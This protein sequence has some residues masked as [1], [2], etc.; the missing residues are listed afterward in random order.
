MS[1]LEWIARLEAL[2]S[3]GHGCASEQGSERQQL[4]AGVREVGDAAAGS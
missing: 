2:E 4:L 3:S 1:E